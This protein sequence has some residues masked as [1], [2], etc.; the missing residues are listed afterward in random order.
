MLRGEKKPGS[1]VIAEGE[2]DMVSYSCR[3]AEDEAVIGIGSGLWTQEHAKKIPNGT[4]VTIATDQDEAGERYAQ[5][6]IKT[7][8]NRCPVWRLVA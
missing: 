6:V 4:L 2:P 7:L 8:N 3:A 1:V 5:E